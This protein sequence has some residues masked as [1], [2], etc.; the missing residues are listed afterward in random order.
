VDRLLFRDPLQNP[1]PPINRE[2][3]VSAKPPGMGSAITP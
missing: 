1:M 3:Q 2:H